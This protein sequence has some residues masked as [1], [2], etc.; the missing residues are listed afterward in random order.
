MLKK[1]HTIHPNFWTFLDN[2]S[3]LIMDQEINYNRLINGLQLS[4]DRNPFNE[5]KNKKIEKAQYYLSSGIYS[6]KEFLQ[7]FSKENLRKQQRIA[8]LIDDDNE[9]EICADLYKEGDVDAVSN[10]NVE[11]MEIKSIGIEN[12]TID[13]L[14]TIE[15]NP[16]EL[17]DTKKEYQKCQVVIQKLNVQTKTK[18]QQKRKPLFTINSNNTNIPAKSIKY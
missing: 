16:N 13:Y 17:E 8:L 1:M 6:L 4:R 7:L 11:N 14:H 9:M 10:A 2:I 15:N 18:R 12:Q 3:K 5:S